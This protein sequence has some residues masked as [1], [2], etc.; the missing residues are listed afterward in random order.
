MRWH[1]M[2][3]K[4][5]LYIRSKRT[6]A[7][8]SVKDTGFIKLPSARTL[9][10]YSHFTKSAL[11]YQ[12]DIVKVLHEEAAKLGMLKGTFKS[13]TGILFDE[14]KIKQDLVYDKHTG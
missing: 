6:E 8:N 4:W 3:V 10:D 14:I 7:Y 9:F 1:P 2:I 13:Y 5:C 12:P 11:G